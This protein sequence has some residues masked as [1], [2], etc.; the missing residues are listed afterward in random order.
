VT[1]SEKERVLAA[2]ERGEAGNVKVGC[3]EWNRAYLEELCDFPYMAHDDEVDASSGAFTKL[4]SAPV[5]VTRPREKDTNVWADVEAAAA[6][7]HPSGVV[8]RPLVPPACRAGRVMSVTTSVIRAIAQ[9][10]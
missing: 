3:A 7:S 10:N 5:A 4:V 2:T 9:F 6:L 8:A 1:L